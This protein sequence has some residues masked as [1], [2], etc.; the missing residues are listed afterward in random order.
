MPALVSKH[1]KEGIDAR[2]QGRILLDLKEWKRLRSLKMCRTS[3][4]SLCITI[5]HSRPCVK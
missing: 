5:T 3:T 4:T 2:G 1:L